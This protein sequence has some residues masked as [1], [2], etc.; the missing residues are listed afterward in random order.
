MKTSIEYFLAIILLVVGAFFAAQPITTSLQ[1]SNAIEYHSSV[2]DR[3]QNSGLD[4]DVIKACISEAQEQGYE[5][6]VEDVSGGE[7]NCYKVTLVYTVKMPII[8]VQKDGSHIG[9][10]R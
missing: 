8:G 10:V 9:Y 6:T 1:K 5:L 7:R 2:M 4:A 3:I